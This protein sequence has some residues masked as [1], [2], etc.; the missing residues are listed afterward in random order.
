[1]MA[2]QRNILGL[3]SEQCIYSLADRTVELEVLPAAQHFGMGVIP[4]SPLGG[5]MLAGILERAGKGRRVSKGTQRKLEKHRNQ[6]EAYEK[7]CKGAG[8][9][10]ADV[11]L[12]WVMTNPA[13]TAPIIGP[14]T[15]D[16]LTDS[17]RV[18]EIMLDDAEMKRL[19]EIWPG[20]GG[21]APESYSW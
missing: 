12:A 5:G 13:V 21:P 3:V 19:D 4:W 16:Q 7:F 1:M 15:L 14:R 17:M 6:V 20:P 9:Q 18:L 11:A 2:R 8:R 10:P